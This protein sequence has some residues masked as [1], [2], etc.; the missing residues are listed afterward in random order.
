MTVVTRPSSADWRS[1][2][3]DREQRALDVFEQRYGEF[4]GRERRHGV[5][6]ILERAADSGDPEV[7]FVIRGH[8]AVYNRKS[9]DLGGFQEVIEP[10]FF[11]DVLDTDPDV[12]AL[13]DH[14]T[15]LALA[16]TRSSKYLLELR[17]DPRGLHY[18]A[19][20]AP[21]SFAADLRVLMEGGVI[22]QASFAFTVADEEWEIVNPGK[23]GEFVLRHLVRCGE[24][25][26]ITVTAQGA[27]P[28][29]D[30]QVVR[31]AALAFARSTG[32]LDSD[33]RTPARTEEDEPT[34][35][36]PE[37]PEA[38][39]ETT[40]AVTEVEKPAE[41]V[42]RTIT[43]AADLRAAILEMYALPG[44][45]LDRADLITRANELQVPALIPSAWGADGTLADER[46]WSTAEKRETY[47]DL[48]EGLETAVEDA[49]VVNGGFYYLWVRDF[50][51][52]NVYFCAGGYLYKAPY[53]V[54]DGPIEV[55]DAVK[56]RPVTEYVETERAAPEGEERKVDV[57]A[58][59]MQAR[60]D[61]DERKRSYLR[62]G[63]KLN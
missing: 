46:A 63:R 38:E 5:P 6:F 60:L 58:M 44:R 7:A 26:D 61:M 51:D 28:Q 12:H 3:G 39:T 54:T 57:K 21:T 14:S 22:D 4:G 47:S 13:W 45:D 49:L 55:G 37:T 59:K 1:T 24:L 16:R 62:A 33:T 36:E 34:V 31:T 53:T 48:R 15:M 42:E 50:D 8:A 17:T 32:R 23:P 29:A 35:T 30:S 27:Y 19:K 25:Y 40:D 52:E 10:G 9:L 11:D 20:V 43:D 2:L 56:V 18:Y 41:P